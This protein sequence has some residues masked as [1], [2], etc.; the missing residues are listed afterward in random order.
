MKSHEIISSQVYAVQL[1]PMY[2]YEFFGDAN[3]LRP[4]EAT[5]GQIPMASRKLQVVEIL[6]FTQIFIKRTINPTARYV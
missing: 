2:D 6:Q 4:E 1:Q 5:F 3:P